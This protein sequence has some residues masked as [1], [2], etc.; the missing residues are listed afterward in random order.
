MTLN[1]D[2][3]LSIGKWLDGDLSDAE[4]NALAGDIRERRHG[5]KL[6]SKVLSKGKR[7]VSPE[8]LAQ[9]QATAA[10]MREINA[11]R[12]TKIDLDAAL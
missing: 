3:Q 8:R 11:Q 1:N 10:R 12:K 2:I 4:L 7:T 6:A 9:L 5:K